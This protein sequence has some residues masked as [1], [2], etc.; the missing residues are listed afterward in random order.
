[1]DYTTAGDAGGQALIALVQG[2]PAGLRL[3]KEQIESDLRRCLSGYGTSSRSLCYVEIVSG[4]R[5]RNTTGAPVAFLVYGDD[6]QKESADVVVAGAVPRPGRGDLAAV[7]KTDADSVEAV[8]SRLDSCDEAACVVAA[9]VAR[10]LLAELGVEVGSQVIRIG[11]EA[12][13]EQE[14]CSS[15]DEYNALEVE[16]SPL[17]CPSQRATEA[18]LAQV[19]TA[20]AAGQTLGGTFQVIARDLLPG[21]GGFAERRKRLT[22]QLAAAL[23]SLPGVVGVEFGDGFAAAAEKGPDFH[24]AV[25]MS[26]AG[27]F[28]RAS[29]HAGGLEDGLTSGETLVITVA[30]APPASAGQPQET[31]NLDTL[32]RDYAFDATAPVCTVPGIAV[33]AEAEVAFVLANAYLDQFGGSN[34]TDMRAAVDSYTHRLK[35]AAR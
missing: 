30:V 12:L 25:V 16:F 28:S 31:V 20:L 29:N 1:M 21:L 10:E 9:S 7:L 15:L 5:G 22:A 8:T 26:A 35:M 18:M 4:A 27:G 3:S 11:M 6:S 32:K 23:F 34:M 13:S 17:R 33:A 24:D 19:N 14:I 2:V